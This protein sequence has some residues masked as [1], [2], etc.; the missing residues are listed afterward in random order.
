MALTSVF[1]QAFLQCR[2]LESWP[3]IRDGQPVINKAGQ[4]MV[5]VMAL[6]RTEVGAKPDTVEVRVPQSGIPKQA[7]VD[8]T[9]IEF[10]NLQ[11]RAWG[12]GGKSGLSFSAESVSVVAT[13]KAAQ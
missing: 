9:A 12:I 10:H 8:G 7:L 6:V 1:I 2:Y 11:A 5:V 3:H 13:G 4:V